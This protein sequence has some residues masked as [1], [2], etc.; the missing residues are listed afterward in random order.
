[1]QIHTPTV[2]QGGSLIDPD[3]EF[4]ISCSHSKRFCLQW[5]AFDVLIKM[6]MMRYI[7]GGGAA[8]G[9]CRHQ[10]GGWQRPLIL[11]LFGFP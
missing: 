3:P 2:V 9:L 11:P 6:M 1:M 10:Q 7:L 8:G 4:L 5:K